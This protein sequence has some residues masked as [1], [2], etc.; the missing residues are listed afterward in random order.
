QVAGASDGAFDPAIGAL[1]GAWGFGAHARGRRAPDAAA[2]VGARDTCG[3]RKLELRRATRELRQPGGLSLDLSAIAKGY[4][5]DAV[6]DLL[7]A[8]GVVAALVDVG[9]ELRGFGRKPDGA[10]WR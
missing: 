7:R 2:L 3:W 9:G 6:A 8:R 10:S 1:V 5:V 4:G